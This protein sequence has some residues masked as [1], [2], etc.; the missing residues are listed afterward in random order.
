MLPAD[1]GVILPRSKDVFLEFREIISKV[2]LKFFAGLSGKLSESRYLLWFCPIWENFS[3]GVQN[4]YRRYICPRSLKGWENLS[5]LN[6]L[7][8]PGAITYDLDCQEDF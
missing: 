7:Y 4:A 3:A 2:F 6:L 1:F 8:N 5:T